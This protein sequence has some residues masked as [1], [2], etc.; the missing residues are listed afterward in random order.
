[1]RVSTGTKLMVDWIVFGPEGEL[2]AGVG[3]GD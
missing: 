2:L 3:V 1:M